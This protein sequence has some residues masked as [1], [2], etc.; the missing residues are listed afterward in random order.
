MLYVQSLQPT[1]PI[2]LDPPVQ[3]LKKEVFPSSFEAY[4]LRVAVRG[5]MPIFPHWK[6]YKRKSSR[7]IIEAYILRVCVSVQ[8]CFFTLFIF[9]HYIIYSIQV[10]ILF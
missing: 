3:S 8:T 9:N 1:W 5:H 2:I 10:L 6:Q 4:I 7:P